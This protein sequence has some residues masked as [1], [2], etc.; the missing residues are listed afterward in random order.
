M[1]GAEPADLGD[2]WREYDGCVA[3]GESA[4]KTHGIKD[5]RHEACEH[6]ACEL[7]PNLAEPRRQPAGKGCDVCIQIDEETLL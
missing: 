4:L 6:S 1:T 3:S 5:Q 2:F 7:P